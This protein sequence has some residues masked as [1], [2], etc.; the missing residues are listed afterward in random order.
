[1]KTAVGIERG[2]KEQIGSVIKDQASNRVLIYIL[3]HTNIQIDRAVS[4]V[5]T[6]VWLDLRNQDGSVMMLEEK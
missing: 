2:S 1:M 5:H 4:D 6:Q 3:C